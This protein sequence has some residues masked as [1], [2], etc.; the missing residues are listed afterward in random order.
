MAARSVT[1]WV[2]FGVW[3]GVAAC[4]AF[5]AL[6][7]FVRPLPVPPTA[8]TV[9]DAQALRGDL[10]LVLGST[11]EPVAQEAPVA[12]L[13]SRF[14]LIGVVSPRSPRAASE[15]LA[16]IAIDGKPP[17]AYRVGAEVD[18]ELVLQRVHARGADLGARDAA[19][20]SV[21]LDVPPL[22]PP[23]TGRPGDV[24]GLSSPPRLPG[25]PMSLAQMQSQMQMSSQ[26]QS[27][28]QVR[29]RLPSPAVTPAAPDPVGEND[30]IADLVEQ[31]LADS[32]PQSRSHPGAQTQ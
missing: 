10:S 25:Q 17:K 24:A 6:K 8:R 27:Q 32:P 1:R 4:A 22:P 7:V 21:A 5:W 19:V 2:T 26:A 11:P 30:D 9:A 3:V 31:E 16:L 18:G 12:A 28:A 13:A 14:K 23:A 15:G 29:P 20:A